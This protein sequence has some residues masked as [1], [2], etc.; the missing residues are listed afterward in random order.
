MTAPRTFDLEHV[1]LNF[2]IGR[3][4]LPDLECLPAL[5]TLGRARGGECVLRKGTERGAGAYEELAFDDGR[6]NG[7]RLRSRRE[8]LRTVSP[9]PDDS[10]EAEQE[11]SAPA[12]GI[13]IVKSLVGS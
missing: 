9:A 1:L 11:A 5:L 4:M 7:R 6:A 13:I 3:G 10:S 12:T 2:V 8:F